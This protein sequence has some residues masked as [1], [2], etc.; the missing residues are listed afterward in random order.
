GRRAQHVES[1]GAGLGAGATRWAREEAARQVPGTED[2]VKTWIPHTKRHARFAGDTVPL[3]E[4]WPAG[5]A[6]GTAPGCRCSMSI[7]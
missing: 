4:N 5:F 2:R 3:G 7:D 1:A 6:P